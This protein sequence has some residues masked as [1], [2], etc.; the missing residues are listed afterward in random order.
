MKLRFALVLCAVVPFLGSCGQMTASTNVGQPTPQAQL[1]QS[2]LSNVNQ[3]RAFVYGG[4][5]QADATQAA[6]ALVASSQ[7]LP[8]LFPPGQ[9]S[10][11]YVDM[12]PER[13]RGAPIAMNQAATALLAAVQTGNRATIGDQLTASERDGCGFCHL[14]TA[15]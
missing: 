1:M 5:S 4:G 10:V 7:R 11:D 2:M 14:S 3:I 9:A 6:Q 8:D 13:A 15:R 12:S